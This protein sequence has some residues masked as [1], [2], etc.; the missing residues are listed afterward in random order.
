MAGISPAFI[1]AFLSV[2]P[3]IAL[4]TAVVNQGNASVVPE[5]V[6][7]VRTPIIMASNFLK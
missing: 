7:A 2:G 4:G 1:T 5:C 6:Q 3:A